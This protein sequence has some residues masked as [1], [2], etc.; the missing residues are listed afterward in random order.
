MH[1]IYKYML[2]GNAK[3]PLTSVKV[4]FVRCYIFF[5]NNTSF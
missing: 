4:C 2:K 1:D 3:T 5:Q